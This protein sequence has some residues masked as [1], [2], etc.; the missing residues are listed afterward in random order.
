M[1]HRALS[2]TI[3]NP[4]QYAEHISEENKLH[5]LAQTIWFRYALPGPRTTSTMLAVLLEG[6]LDQILFDEMEL[7]IKLDFT[8]SCK[9]FFLLFF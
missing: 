4:L 8:R 1:F 6:L 9:S 5:L 2:D 3:V 7:Q